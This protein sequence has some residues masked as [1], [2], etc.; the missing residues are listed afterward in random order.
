MVYNV[1]NPASHA[2]YMPAW[3]CLC[4]DT[5]AD[6]LKQLLWMDPFSGQ[7]DAKAHKPSA[8]VDHRRG[9]AHLWHGGQ[10][11]HAHHDVP[12]AD[13]DHAQD[14]RLRE[15]RC[16]AKA[17][18]IRQGFGSIGLVPWVVDPRI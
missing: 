14:Q 9:T 15:E 18:R 7:E 8:G 13:M 5:Q 6:A 12:D 4:F 1:P 3:V 10:P 17:A 11:V 16:T 2:E